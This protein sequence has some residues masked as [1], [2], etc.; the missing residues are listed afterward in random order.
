LPDFTGSTT[1]LPI[2]PD[3]EKQTLIK[4]IESLQN[5]LKTSQSSL[6]K[7]TDQQEELKQQIRAL[8]LDKEE[9][10]RKL[11]TPSE[12]PTIG[13]PR[14]IIPGDFPALPFLTSTP[15]ASKKLEK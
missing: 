10:L 7:L 15:K 8:K 3:K 2:S 4:H 6:E 11:A 1:S 9:L 13:S 5:S 14:P 12:T